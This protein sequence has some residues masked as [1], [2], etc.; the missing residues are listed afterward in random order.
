MAGCLLY[1]FGDDVGRH[2]TPR[3]PFSRRQP[4]F[5]INVAEQTK[6][7]IYITATGAF[8]LVISVTWIYHINVMV[9][10]KFD[11]VIGYLVVRGG[12]LDLV[13]CL[14]LLLLTVCHQCFWNKFF[15]NSF[16]SLTYDYTID[17]AVKAGGVL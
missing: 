14:E 2:S 9:L 1:E 7:S 5:Y 13:G 6:L 3:K 10:D 8:P 12:E 15:I 4:A 11:P 16:R 17:G